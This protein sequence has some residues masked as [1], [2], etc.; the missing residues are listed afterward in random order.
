MYITCKACGV[1]K[2]T[3]DFPRDKRKPNG[4]HT[5]CKTCLAARA[6]AGRVGITCTKAWAVNEKPCN[7]CGEIKVLN[8]DNWYPVRTRF[9]NFDSMCRECRNQ[10]L[11]DH[12]KKLYHSKRHS[13][14]RQRDLDGSKRKH[15]AAKVACV[16]YLGGECMK[17]GTKYDGTNA[18]I[19]DFHHRDPTRKKHQ[20]LHRG[21]K[22]LAGQKEELDKCDL[23]CANC[24]RLQHS[25]RF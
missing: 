11:K 21:P 1:S 12:R 14:Q 7:T 4:V 15:R 25:E 20:I 3:T 24:H 16:Q 8:H 17:C 9:D 2:D 23:L 18:P 6:R 13:E 5:Q 19:F 22:T 10:Y